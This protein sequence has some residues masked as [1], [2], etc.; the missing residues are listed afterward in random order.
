MQIFISKVEWYSDE[1]QTDTIFVSADTFVNAM[2]SIV[3]YYGDALCCVRYLEPW[4]NILH[5]DD[6]FMRDIE[7]VKN[8]KG[9]E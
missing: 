4:G 6:D 3:D 8:E 2:G 7:R 1:V 5:I 9:V